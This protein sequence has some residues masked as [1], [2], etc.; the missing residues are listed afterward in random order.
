VRSFLRHQLEKQYAGPTPEQRQTDHIYLYAKAHNAA[1]EM[2][3]AW[4]ET[5]EGYH[6]TSVASVSVVERVLD[7]NY[8][9]AL[10]PASAFGADFAL[11]I[12]GTKARGSSRLE[13]VWI[14]QCEQTRLP[15]QRSVMV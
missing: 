4:M 10:T 15:L 8:A 2:A 11:G 9:G 13:F 14:V 1:G 6:F 3:E 7:G 5:S 12:E